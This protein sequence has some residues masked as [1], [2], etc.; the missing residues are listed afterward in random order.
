M[1]TANGS[2]DAVIVAIGCLRL[3]PNVAL[4]A[5][6]PEAVAAANRANHSCAYGSPWPSSGASSV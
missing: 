3:M 4:D 1:V 6:A 5:P 2:V